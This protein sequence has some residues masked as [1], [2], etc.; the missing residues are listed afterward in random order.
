MKKLEVQK[1]QMFPLKS[2]NS[3]L[4]RFVNEQDEPIKISP[5]HVLVI[6]L[7]FIANV[8]LLH[9]YAKF[10]SSSSIYRMTFGAIIV[11]MSVLFGISMNKRKF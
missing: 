3:S 4:E 11:L 7:L 5:V 1:R 10:G 8:F 6:S 2:R 9:L